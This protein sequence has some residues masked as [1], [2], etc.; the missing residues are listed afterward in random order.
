MWAAVSV[1]PVSAVKSAPDPMTELTLY[2]GSRPPHL[3]GYLETARGQF[4]LEPLPDGRTRL[5][6]RTW[7][8]THMV[9]EAYW[10]LWADPILARIHERVLAHVK[11]L[12]ESDPH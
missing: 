3:D 7:Y 10:R 12:A 6:G 11:A 4:L 2:R 5:T 1:V 9:P 8:R